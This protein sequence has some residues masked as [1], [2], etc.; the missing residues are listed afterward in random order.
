MPEYKLQPD[1]FEMETST[2]W[3][4]PK[5]GNWATHNP[6][7][8]GNW[9]PQIPRNLILRYSKPK[10]LV[11]DQM[12]G[13]GTTLI[14]CKLTDRNALGFDINPKM[15]ELSRD[16]LKFDS[17]DVTP[18]TEIKIKVGDARNLTEVKDESIDLIA[19]H[20]PYVDIIKYSEGKIE[21]DLSNIHNMDKFCDEMKKVA[22]ECYR[23][24]KPNKYCGILIGDTRRKKYFIPMAY[25]VMQNFID[26]G[27][28]LKEDIIKHQ[29]N[30][31]TTPYWASMSKNYNFLLIMH[32][33][34]FVFEKP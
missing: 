2:V 28:K 24:L 8:R 5:R 11:L 32:E 30:C 17:D 3:S 25:K 9:A 27:F 21:E 14:E 29:Y 15:V 33:H 1:S 4:F 16:S 10:D 22:E 6:K 34:L 7:F 23:I 13:G 19:T 26:A 20:P 31:K 18:K 12:C